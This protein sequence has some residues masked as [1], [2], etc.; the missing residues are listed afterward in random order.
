[1]PKDARHVAVTP[2]RCSSG[3]VQWVPARTATPALSITVATSWACAPSMVKDTM[4][5]LFLA[6]P[7][8]RSELISDSRAM[9]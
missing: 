2:K 4:A 8:I 3:C 1:M 9:A 5:P 6:R 7:K